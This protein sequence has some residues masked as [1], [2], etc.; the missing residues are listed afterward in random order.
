MSADGLA[1]CRH[2]AWQ[3]RQS[4][5][6]LSSGSTP[7][8]CRR[9]K[10]SGA[11]PGASITRTT[12]DPSAHYL[13]VTVIDVAEHTAYLDPLTGTGLLLLPTDTDTS[14]PEWHSTLEE[15]DQRGWIL[16]DDEAGKPEVAGSTADGLIALCLY[17]DTAIIEAPSLA[18]IYRALTGLRYAAGLRPD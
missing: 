12:I 17:G 3:R 2:P 4:N 13:D 1:T 8:A 16:L 15:L 5:W 6:V 10:T 11:C 14:S 7:S 18:E 9:R